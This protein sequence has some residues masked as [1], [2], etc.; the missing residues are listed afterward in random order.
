MRYKF[1]TI[2][3]ILVC[4][5]LLTSVVQAAGFVYSG[6]RKEIK[7]GVL[8]FKYNNAGNI[9]YSR[10]SDPYIFYV[11]DQR[12][13]LKPA[14]WEFV[15]PLAP[16]R[17][18]PDIINRWGSAY[19]AGDQVTKD[20]ACYWEVKIDAPFSD[21][22]KFDV[23]FMTCPSSSNLLLKPRDIEKLRKMVDAGG[24]IWIED[25]GGARFSDTNAFFIRDLDFGTGGSPGL[26]DVPNPAHPLLTM[27]FTLSWEEVS[28]LGP[29]PELIGRNFI[30]AA[31]PHYF[32]PVVLS[33]GR[34][35]VA[36][37]QY[38]SGHIVAVGENVGTAISAAVGNGPYAKQNW[39]LA[40]TEDLKFA[41]NIVSWGSEHTT[42]HKNPRHTGYSFERMSNNLAILWKFL[43]PT[44]SM[45]TG[46]SP[47]FLDNMVFYVDN[48]GIL[49]AFDLM[50]ERDRDNDGNPDDGKP[51]FG[52]G[53]PYDEVWFD[54]VGP[55][56]SPTT[57]YVSVG[58]N[59]IPAVFVT[60]KE[61]KVI[62]YCARDGSQKHD[63]LNLGVPF[64]SDYD[65]P[66]PT[67]CDGVLYCGSSDGRLYAH[68]YNRD[69]S[70]VWPRPPQFS[71]IGQ[72]LNS[73]T[74][75]YFRNPATGAVDQ[76]LHL[77]T[78]GIK[79]TSDGA[80]QCF[81]I[82]VF[83]EPLKKVGAT[84]TGTSIYEIALPSTAIIETPGS[85][86]VYY[87][88]PDGTIEDV[89]GN[90]IRINQPG[91]FEINESAPKQIPPGTG[92]FA[93]YEVDYASSLATGMYRQRITVKTR[94]PTGIGP[95]GVGVLSTPAAGP[96]DVLYYIA[97]NG[98]IYAAQESGRGAAVIKWRWF[99]GD[100]G[101]VQLLG[102][103]A[104]PV[105]S[106]VIGDDIVYV[107]VNVDGQGMILAFEADPSFVINTGVPIDRRR[108]V[109][110][111]QFDTLNPG[112]EPVPIG[113]A[114]E[115]S[116]GTAAYR[117]DYERGR[118]TFVN[119]RDPRN[120]QTELSASQ[121]LVVKFYIAEEA[122]GS[123]TPESQCH[124]AFPPSA[125]SVASTC[126]WYPNDSWNNLRWFARLP[127]NPLGKTEITS[128]PAL[129]GD[130]LFVGCANG[131]IAVLDVGKL[132][133]KFRGP[134]SNVSQDPES[135]KLIRVFPAMPGINPPSVAGNVWATVAG[136]NGILAVATQAGLVVLHNGLTLVADGKRILE[137]DA[138]GSAVWSC[139]STISFVR[140]TSPAGDVYSQVNTPL[141][142]PSVARRTVGGGIV[143]AD[144]GNN[145]VVLI[146]RA[147]K[148]LWQISDF[149]DPRKSTP[150][151][152][153]KPNDS[154]NEPTDVYMWIQRDRSTGYPEYHYLIA[155]AGK[156]RIVEIAAKYIDNVGFVNELVWTTR[157]FEQGKRYRFKKLWSDFPQGRRSTLIAIVTN[158]QPQSPDPSDATLPDPTLAPEAIGRERE[159]GALVVIDPSPDMTAADLATNPSAGLIR[160]VVTEI[161]AVNGKKFQ[162]FNP[163]CFDRYKVSNTRYYDLITDSRGIYIIDH[164]VSG[165]KDVIQDIYACMSTD[166]F[167]ATGRLM[168]PVHGKILPSLNVLITNMA[169]WAG[170]PFGFSGEIV[171]L[172][173]TSW[174]SNCG[175]VGT[176]SAIPGSYE[177]QQPSSAERQ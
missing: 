47:A 173:P 60:T 134:C 42:F 101:A 119:F 146:D 137:I 92:L 3:A 18:T 64:A 90:V 156:Y 140:S 9:E 72:V 53:T 158:Y 51:D 166:Y 109:E 163:T 22:A 116:G 125:G 85:Y 89:T 48:Q 88:L 111:Y 62:G 123:G 55:A 96:N 36:A 5:V 49:H 91:K 145:R 56:S 132:N 39:M 86:Q 171:E 121:D 68:D 15:N 25:R 167:K 104:L 23:L 29:G 133:E 82:K 27:P 73:P 168:M 160:T 69:I 74:I 176:I 57:A 79:G 162:L 136:Q 44:G 113:G 94:R 14:G 155:D 34:L 38:G 7:A 115:D 107:A 139:D 50:P 67:F 37:A 77:A 99:L 54:Q 103:Q 135:V 17:V 154:L 143:V 45:E 175:I 108:P 58:G 98:S 129:I 122:G 114:P 59:F 12:S 141:N 105:G 21:L 46:S 11:M 100:P 148:V 28:N 174:P 131:M 80:I 93:N 52:T 177:L 76:V 126:Q 83:G 75:G 120:S 71:G 124:A 78:R 2:I 95:E 106:P 161:E 170:G 26:A 4:I 13:E 41:Y 172:D 87:V 149:V 19:K 20:M 35:I 6:S 97:E 32:A 70:W 127:N 165:G 142:R 112:V 63:A 84:G 147:G 144:T 153:Y 10:A 130:T 128:S 150:Q 110:V 151:D 33:Q 24:V 30:S 152:P 65:I 1:I 66:A 31:D 81:P 61:G 16:S 117:V 169:S 157:T 118:I 8:I 138:G 43:T 40:Q 164:A 102:G 159:G